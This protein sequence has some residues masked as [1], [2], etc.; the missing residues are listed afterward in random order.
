MKLLMFKIYFEKKKRFEKTK[1]V[2]YKMHYGNFKIINLFS[3]TSKSP[4]Y[5][6][7]NIILKDYRIGI[8]G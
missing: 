1:K 3:Y 4:F 8:I 7:T 5:I 6:S 2:S